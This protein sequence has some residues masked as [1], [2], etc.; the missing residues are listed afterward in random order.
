MNNP[1][2]APGHFE[3]PPVDPGCEQPGFTPRNSSPLSS[4]STQKKHPVFF[5]F[6]DF[7]D[8][9]VLVYTIATRL[10]GAQRQRPPCEIVQRLERVKHAGSG[11]NRLM[12]WVPL[13]MPV[14]F[15]PNRRTA[16]G[17][18]NGTHRKTQTK[19]ALI[20]R[21]RR[22]LHS[23]DSMVAIAHTIPSREFWSCAI[24]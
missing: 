13:A 15:E 24:C 5:D 10:G 2:I 22:V 8:F 23:R 1:L 21:W 9:F 4:S 14:L 17:I 18:G 12:S 7:F 16:L 20:S 6:F 11:N 3:M 19:C